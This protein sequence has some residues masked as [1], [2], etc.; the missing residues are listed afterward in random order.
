VQPSGWYPDPDGTPGRLRWWDGQAWTDLTTQAVGDVPPA[1]APPVAPAHGVGAHPDGVHQPEVLVGPGGA[2][3]RPRLRWQPTLPRWSPGRGWQVGGPVVGLVLILVLVAALNGGRRGDDGQ[4]AVATPSASSPAPSD[5]TPP[6]A[7]LCPAGRTTAPPS[8]VPSEPAPAGPRLTDAQAGISYLKGGAPWQPWDRLW[9]GGVLGVVYRTGY[10]FVTQ[11]NVGGTGDDYLATVLSGSVPA[12]VGDALHP[13]M[14]C[15]AH[16]VVED[17]R[18]SFYP[19]P[20]TREV[21]EDRPVVVDGHPG[22]L[23][24]FHLSFDVPGYDAKG[25]LASVLVVDV[26]TPRV[27][28]LYQSIPDT[29]RRFDPM[30]DRVVASVRVP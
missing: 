20:N 23:V 22:Y 11:H 14:A 6:L 13:D 9:G 10:F 3:R 21:R 8:A 18:R 19:D 24:T 28:V 29:H 4:L 7:R 15:V 27:A 17:V 5:D 16:Q 2:E 30:I 1:G 12:T 25:E 26:G